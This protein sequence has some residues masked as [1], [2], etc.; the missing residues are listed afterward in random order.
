MR[1]VHLRSCGVSEVLP[2]AGG[3]TGEVAAI[4]DSKPNFGDKQKPL[5]LMPLKW[6]KLIGKPKV[7]DYSCFA[8]YVCAAVKITAQTTR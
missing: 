4:V 8:V 3:G 5:Y 2:A 7:W 1:S 6:R